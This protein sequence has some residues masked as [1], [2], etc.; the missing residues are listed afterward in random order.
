MML[1]YNEKKIKLTLFFLICQVCAG[2]G[3]KK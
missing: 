2:W 1:K 3:I